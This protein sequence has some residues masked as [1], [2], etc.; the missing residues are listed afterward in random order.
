MFKKGTADYEK[1]IRIHI[2]LSPGIYK[3][4][5]FSFSMFLCEVIVYMVL[6]FL[7]FMIAFHLTSI[8][9]QRNYEVTN[10]RVV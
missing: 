2:K 1:S 3:M 5:S 7:L 8:P 9:T 10:L 6:D 4:F